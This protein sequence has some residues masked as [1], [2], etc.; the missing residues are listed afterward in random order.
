MAIYGTPEDARLKKQ[1]AQETAKQRSAGIQNPNLGGIVSKF[2]DEEMAAKTL[3]MKNAGQLE[4]QE[5]SL[6]LGQG[7]LE[8]SREQ[9]AM[10]KANTRRNIANRQA[11]LDAAKSQFP[12]NTALGGVG[13]ALKVGGAYADRQS[14]NKNIA[15]QKQMMSIMQSTSNAQLQH[16]AAMANS[17]MSAGTG[18]FSPATPPPQT[19]HTPNQG[20]LG[21]LETYRGQQRLYGGA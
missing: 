9:L 3:A 19:A 17:L 2:A 6:A 15:V 13:A 7:R 1:I 20:A 12:I 5:R 8:L 18:S 21:M 11:E 16:T 10:D 4:N 14:S